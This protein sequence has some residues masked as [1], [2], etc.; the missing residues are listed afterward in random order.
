MDQQTLDTQSGQCHCH[1]LRLLNHNGGHCRHTPRRRRTIPISPYPYRSSILLST[2]SRHHQRAISGTRRTFECST[3]S[4]SSPVATGMGIDGSAAQGRGHLH[5]LEVPRKTSPPPE[6]PGTLNLTPTLHHQKSRII[7]FSGVISFKMA[8]KTEWEDVLMKHG[9]MEKPEVVPTDDEEAFADQERRAAKD[10][11]KEKTLD[12]L[13]EMEDDVEEDVLAK[14]RRKR[15]DEL[16]SKA[17]LNKFG[18]VEY[19]QKADFLQQVNKAGPGIWVVLHL[20]SSAAASRLLAKHMETLANKFRAVKFL[21]IQYSECIPNYPESK[22]P[23][24][25]LYKDDDLKANVVG[26]TSFGGLKMTALSLEWGLSRLGVL[27]TEL[28][29]DPLSG[30]SNTITVQKNFVRHRDED[31][32]DSENSD[33]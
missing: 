24:L 31:Q 3:R 5:V 12:Q 19:M 20:E 2:P 26:I 4:R 11:L 32:S 27:D 16:K 22:T 18:K 28:E 33:F 8:G 30:Q 15:L 29:A 25:L 17:A 21:R 10:P 9:I 14:L 7:G 1:G 6:V 13:N 23:T